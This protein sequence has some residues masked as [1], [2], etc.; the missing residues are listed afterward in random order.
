MNLVYL[1]SARLPTEKAHGY[2]IVKMC[3][4][5]ANDID[6]RLL[7]PNRK[8]TDELKKVADI[9]GFYE[10]KANFVMTRLP[11][12]DWRWL[13]RWGMPRLR[14]FLM[15]FSFSVVAVLWIL[16]RRKLF[17]VVYSRDPFTL[18]ALK[19]FRKR[20]GAQLAYEC[21]DFPKRRIRSRIALANQVNVVI[22]VTGKIKERFV[23][24]RVDGEKILVAP[25][26]VDLAQFDLPLTRADARIKLRLAS[27]MRMATFVGRFHTMEMEKG[28]P[29]II[30]AAAN[31]IPAFTDLYFYFVGGPLDRESRYRHI[32]EELALPQD[33]FVFLDRQ[34]VRDVPI[35]LKASDV[36]LMPFPNEPHFALSMSPLKMF[37]YMASQRPIVAS[38]LP[39]VME[40]LRHE[41]NAL[42][43]SPGDA[44]DIADRIRKLL[45][46]HRLGERLAARAF[47][48]VQP[49]TWEKRAEGILA[50][51][52]KISDREN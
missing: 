39:A 28:I 17:D 20:I 34:P 41:E 30:R 52:E 42:L 9:P 25:D 26:A 40:V 21:H 18:R 3:E 1:T 22:A 50:F 24:A 4:A 36:L 43:G 27:G 47:A 14:F 6:V 37:E 5:F 8:N 38:K 10:A 46:N 2:Q 32:V 15:Q 49:H 51:V 35:W 45:E 11:C 19:F 13:E 16:R 12:L 33:R 23:D 31:L 44:A 29:E 48:D 7:F